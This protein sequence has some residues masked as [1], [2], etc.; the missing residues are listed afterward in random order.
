MTEEEEL[1]HIQENAKLV[2]ERFAAFS[3]LGERFGYNLESIEWLEGHIERQRKD[4]EFGP[5]PGLRLI[6]ILGS[7]LG[8]CIIHICG[9]QWRL[10]EELGWGVLLKDGNT[11]FPF[12]KLRKLFE[13]GVEGGDSILS[14][15]S[16]TDYFLREG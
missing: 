10:N 8:E 15:L 14:F 2:V 9:G 11:A 12:N 5:D 6:S 7:Y 4:P 3:G 1:I 16:A 13:N